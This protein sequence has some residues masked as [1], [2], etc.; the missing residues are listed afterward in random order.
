MKKFFSPVH[1]NL[2]SITA[3]GLGEKILSPYLASNR[4][5]CSI[6]PFKNMAV[7]GYDIR[8]VYCVWERIELDEGA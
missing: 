1:S 4:P 7:E 5:C 8:V 2:K 3:V 6:W